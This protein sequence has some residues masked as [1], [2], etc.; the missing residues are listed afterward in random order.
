VAISF[1]LSITSALPSGL[2]HIPF[3]P[4]IDFAELIRSTGAAGLFDP[5]SVEIINLATGRRVEYARSEDFAYG[6]C[7]RL[8]WAITDPA[9]IEY[10][11]RFETAAARPALQPQ[12]YV[13][14]VGVG[15]LLRYNA[16][17]PR[18]VTLFYAMKLVDLTG[19]GRADLAGCWNYYHRPGA[20]ISGVVCY[21]R[22]GREDDFLFGDLARLR[23]R[24]PG[25]EELRHFP[26]VYVEADFADVNGD[27]LVDIAFAEWSGRAVTFFLN[28]GE[29]D[30]GGLPI[31]ERSLTVPA[32]LESLQG[33][34][35]IDLDGDGV[36]D[37]VVHGHFIRNASPA[38]WPFLPEAPVELGIGHQVAF[39]DLDGDSALDALCLEHPEDPAQFGTIV[40]RKRTG[41]LTF[42]PAEPVAGFDGFESIT[43]IAVV[44]GEPFHGILLQS[45]EYQCITAFELIPG[46]EPRFERRQRAESLSAVIS[47]SDQA[48]PCVYDWDG[49]GAWD[50]LVGCGYGWIR[51]L[52]NRGS[53]ARPAFDMPEKVLADGKPLRLLRDELLFSTHWHNMGY[54]YPVFVDW[55]GDGLPDLLL[56]NETNRI[57]W[58]RNIGTPGEPRFGP[59][60][61]LEVEDFPDSPELRAASGQD[62]MNEALPNYPYPADDRSPF[63]WRAGAAF[64]DWNGDGLMD[65][66]TS[67]A[68]HKATLFVQYRDEDG[69]LR[70]KRQ[71]HVRLA[72]GRLID[73]SIVG[74][75]AHW[76]ESF[77]AVDWDGDGL[78][79]LLYSLAGS[80]EIYLLRNV[81]TRIEPAFAPPRQLK[82]YGEPLSFTLHGPHPWAADLNGDG[83]PDLLGCVEWS[84]YP[85][86]AHAAL[87]MEAHPEYL[88]ELLDKDF[89]AC[90]AN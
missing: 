49:D 24:E 70:L 88:I 79:D 55:D 31:F 57:L 74:R 64:A 65:F 45:Q 58:C 3:S 26:G 50:L 69:R 8:A 10:E 59:P 66:I 51:V 29:R 11:I 42:G 56:P 84:V 73:D 53:N 81:G 4:V 87:E 16:G 77:R 21:P 12:A 90:E 47:A 14:M 6:D 67:G 46:P 75:E 33:L 9:H 13:P 71:G 1:R 68:D 72:D 86:Y 22:A 18:P 62:G 52:R 37:L 40:W 61:F 36:L 17:A 5:N 38:G 78:T 35:V 85:F 76:T 54:P 2:G 7:G 44:A 32:P 63:C 27:G 30:G 43:H 41:T 25:E 80:A 34:Q 20:P 15:D 23:Y 19:D 89:T 82:C 48:W 83:K 60:Q 39:L 28:T